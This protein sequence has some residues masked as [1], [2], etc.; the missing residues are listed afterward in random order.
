MNVNPEYVAGKIA[1]EKIGVHW[2]TLHRYDAKGFI[3]TIRTPG[4][5][6]LYNVKKFMEERDKNIPVNKENICYCRVS[7]HGQK[8]DLKSQVQ[9]MK[10][11]YPTYRIITD[12]GSGVNFKR[13]G[14]LEI[15]NLAIN[16]KL[17]KIVVSYE[18]RLCRIGFELIEYIL[19]NYSDTTIIIENKGDETDEE[20][21][22]KDV[23]QIITVYVAK[24]HGK[25]RYNT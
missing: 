25:R 20:K 1:Q 3:D 24:V 7:T 13:K 14:L 22:A 10:S 4:G 5:K 17:K 21:I 9:Y 2:S 6:R 15:I 16:N 12:I 11:K 19:K 18:D 23:L 8:N